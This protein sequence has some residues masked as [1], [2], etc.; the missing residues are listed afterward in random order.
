M[1]G[2]NPATAWAEL[3]AGNQRFIS[4]TPLH[5]HQ[6]A[7]RRTQTAGAQTPRAALFGCSDSRLSA[8]I[9][10]DQGLG[11]LFVVRN[12]GQVV[13]SSV[14]GSLEYAVSSV[15][16]SVIVVLAHDGCGAVHAAI[17]KDAEPDTFLPAHVGEIIDQIIPAVS[18]VRHSA[19]L[20]AGAYVDADAVGREHLKDTISALLESSELIG[21]KIADGTLAIVGATYRLSEG[22]VTPEVV[23]GDIN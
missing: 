10:F 11:D 16:V 4:E 9:I 20:P 2:A 19:G 15:G 8:E 5:P 13:S 3:V 22:H 18:R 12:I 14:I 6:D 23:V 7:E 1:T 17:T 21:E